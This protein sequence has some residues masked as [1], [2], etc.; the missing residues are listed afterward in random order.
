MNNNFVHRGGNDKRGNGAPKT[1]Q[2]YQPFKPF[3][4]LAQTKQAPVASK[5]PAVI[6]P[7]Q[8]PNEIITVATLLKSMRKTNPKVTMQLMKPVLNDL[9]LNSP[10]AELDADSI[11]LLC[12]ELSIPAVRTKPAKIETV[13]HPLRPPI[14][15]IMGHVDHG[16]TTLL[17]HLRAKVTADGN[18]KKKE[19]AGDVAGTEA[20]GITQVITSFNLPVP[21][22]HTSE[23][24]ATSVTF[25]DTP[26]HAAFS[27]MRSSG[28]CAA[29]IIVMVVAADD[30]V[31]VQ[32]EEVAKLASAS[33][34][35]VIV[36][37]TK[38]DKNGVS[39]SESKKKIESQLSALNIIT[40]S[41]GGEVMVV[42]V[43]GITGEG[44]GTLL[45]NLI[46]M[47]EVADLRSSETDPGEAIVIDARVSKGLGVVADCIVRSGRIQPG[48]YVV[49]GTHYGK[50]KRIQHTDNNIK[51]VMKTAG[52]AMPVRLVGF[53]T[54]PA[55]GD[56]LRVVKDEG[57]AKRLT[58]SRARIIAENAVAEESDRASARTLDI[59]L[60][61][62]AARVKSRIE[63]QNAA[64][65][66]GLAYGKRGGN[67]KR[68]DFHLTAPD[69]SLLAPRAP[70]ILKAD[71]D[72]VL[73][74]VRDCLLSLQSESKVPIEIDIVSSSVG[75]V[76]QEDVNLASE[77]NGLIFA[78]NVKANSREV[79][80]L[81]G[82]LGVDIRSH[83]I[84]YSL[85]D[86]ARVELG[87]FLPYTVEEQQ[88]GR[89]TVLQTFELSGSAK[90]RKN[91][92]VIAGGSVEGATM[93]LLEDPKGNEAR[94]RVYKKNRP[95]KP[96]ASELKGLSLRKFKKQVTS[97]QAGEE[98][99]L[100]LE[101]F[102]DFE[103]GDEIECYVNVK[104]VPVL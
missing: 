19:V 30:G 76:T 23:D 39:V 11:E 2:P 47:A 34:V 35:S 38:I 45:D 96:I 17:D 56:P 6:P 36:A 33:G 74:A 48:D 42:P 24:L 69:D 46:I 86:D 14:V 63:Q 100:S 52:P 4:P 41:F 65:A 16:K 60:T 62:G 1:F 99:G 66:Q 71:C 27:A 73:S 67:Q 88:L 49:S 28:S 72:G 59:Q 31:N 94:F 81:C 43:S 97:V 12:M 58:D 93:Y 51:A 26:G 10:N 21:K 104:V 103:E 90:Q 70:I 98:C 29:D 15:T 9:D 8:I 25:L 13:I 44:V 80:K 92:E 79:Q 82:E 102:T 91:V 57:T 37:M 32:T 5:K 75:A 95:S 83:K 77:A 101:G 89:L 22:S 54:V 87:R 78:F 55:A 3:K 7:F 61:G 18:K 20:G 50:V 40:E 64:F 85:I 68:Q 53:K 84:I